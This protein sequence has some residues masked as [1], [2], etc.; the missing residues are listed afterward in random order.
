MRVKA[1][2]PE[3]TDLVERLPDFQDKNSVLGKLKQGFHRGLR[4]P[5][6]GG[7]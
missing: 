4:F 6:G 5:E 3:Q 7:R 2:V 1:P